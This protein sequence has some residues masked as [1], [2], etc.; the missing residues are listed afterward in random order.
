M[1]LRG[2][3]FS[4]GLTTNL[5]GEEDPWLTMM[6]TKTTHY[7]MLKALEAGQRLILQALGI[8]ALVY[9]VIRAMWR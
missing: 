7:E 9:E 6:I 1:L 3:C 4:C 8:A 5:S 2:L